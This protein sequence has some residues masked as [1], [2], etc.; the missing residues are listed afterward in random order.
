[1]KVSVWMMELLLALAFF[2]RVQAEAEAALRG[3]MSVVKP[4]FPFEE[5]AGKQRKLQLGS[6]QSDCDYDSD[7]SFICC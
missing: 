1:M 2:G 7:V 6:C 3:P 5:E 4:Q